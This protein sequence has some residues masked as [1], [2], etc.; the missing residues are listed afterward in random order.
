[1]SLSLVVV[2]WECAGYLTRLV[3]SLNRYLDPSAELIVIDNASSDDPRAA[4]ELWRGPVRFERLDTNVGFGTASNRGVQLSQ[5]DAVVLLNPDTELLDDG[6]PRLAA[7]ALE[8]QC[9]AGPRLLNPDRSVQPSASGSP[10]GA[11]PWLGAVVP[12]RLQPRFAR[13]KTEPWRLGSRTRVAWLSAACI[14]APRDIL[15][16]LGPFDPAIHL[17]AEDMDLGLRAGALGIDSWF[18]PELSRVAHRRRG[19]TERRWPGGPEE[20]AA[21][22]RR[23]VVRRTYGPAAERRGWWAHRT[24]LR[25][26]AS[27]KRLLRKDAEAELSALAATRRAA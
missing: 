26:R 11:W 3:A 17:Y 1:L 15:Q 24:N 6:L 16:R 5:G 18:C 9:I 8:H 4:A 23:T 25:L 19:S 7:F 22:N 2:S 14:A 27:A 12:G 13:T 21:I 20:P 10:V